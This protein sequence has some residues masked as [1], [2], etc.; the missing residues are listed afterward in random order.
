MS[1]LFCGR[2]TKK[3]GRLCR[4]RI[5]IDRTCE[6]HGTVLAEAVPFRAIEARE[7]AMRPAPGPP[8][9]RPIASRPAQ[10]P[11]AAPGVPL[12]VAS[13][14]VPGVCWWLVEQA[15]GAEDWDAR[16]AGVAVQM[17]RLL[18]TLPPDA[19]TD[20]E[21]RDEAFLRGK[22]VNGI[23]PETGDEW[24]LAEAI[25]TDEA[26]DELRSWN[27]L[28]EADYQYIREPL[29]LTE[30]AGVEAQPPIFDDQH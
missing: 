13:R 16:W 5:A 20:E 4:W 24:A 11:Q 30:D 29:V 28:R 3:P 23:P 7:A 10:P 1:A 2:Q 26:L 6:V 17:V 18:V 9:G 8:T 12:P 21:K 19:L 14:N 27:Q 22:I 25:F 15:T